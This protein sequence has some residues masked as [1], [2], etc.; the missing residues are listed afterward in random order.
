M[1]RHRAPPGVG[2]RAEH[3]LPG[4]D[5]RPQP[6]QADRRARSPS[7]SVLHLDM[8]KKEARS[9]AVELLRSVGIP[10]PEERVRWYPFQLSGGMRQRVMIAIALACA[11]RLVMADEPTTGL[12][13]TVQAQILDLL[14]DLQRERHMAVILV[15][16]DLG[17]V[18]S[19]ADDIIVMY[20]GRIV[21]RAPTRT[22]FS[23]TK[24]PYTRALMDS[25]PRLADP[26]GA[27]LDA[28]A[29]RPPD[30]INPPAGLPVRPPLPLRPGQVPGV[31]AAAAHRRLARPPLRLLVP[32]GRRRVDRAPSVPVDRCRRPTPAAAPHGRPSR[33]RA[34]GRGGRMSD[35]TAD[36]TDT[37]ASQR[38]RRRARRA[39]P[40][41][42]VQERPPAGPGRVR[43]SPS[44]S[45]R[46]RRSA[47]SASP[48]AASRPPVA[49]WSRSSRPP[50][51]PSST[52]V[53]T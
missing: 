29:G 19:R 12:D 14:A 50:R 40:G 9:T 16:H 24:M 20:A 47:S 26:S 25:I 31:G 38:R 37:T 22:L 43:A 35:D 41:R 53:R 32:A 46:A 4:P 49:P 27:R 45:A 3:D 2:R 21:E 7:R 30:L 17:V 10:S 8:D 39:G 48:A 15:T 28:I 11:P 1:E 13:V 23:D 51:A 44:R 52:R 33:S 18:A 5:D 42:R 34:H 36:T 6:G